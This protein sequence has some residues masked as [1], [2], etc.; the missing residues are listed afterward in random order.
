MD[1]IKFREKNSQ[2]LNRIELANQFVNGLTYQEGIEKEL[3]FYYKKL[4]TGSHLGSLNPVY[5]APELSAA[6]IAVAR[7]N[8]GVSGGLMV[9]GSSLSGKT[10]FLETIA[11]H[12][13]KGEKYYISPFGKQNYTA[14]DIDHAIQNAFGKKGSA[15][16]ILSQLDAQSILIFDDLEQ[17]WTKSPKG[18]QSID[19]LLTLMEK[20][21]HQHYFLLSCN[22]SSFDIIRKVTDIDKQLIATILVPPASKLELKEILLN[23]HK[24]AGDE[25]WYDNH[26]IG[27]SKKTDAIFHEIYALSKGNVGV[28]LNMWIHNIDKDAD[29]QLILN[30]PRTMQFPEITD[31]N[32]KIVLYHLV[33]HGSWSISQIELIFAEA[34]W[35]FATL[36][37]LEKTGLVHQ[38][39]NTVYVLHHAA[40]PY[41]E[42]WLATLKILN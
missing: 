22:I 32:W 23:R 30:K 36:K 7:I 12:Q 2:Y 10:Y 18:A 41:I 28:A 40:K 42:S 5:K 16:A 33:L 17:W 13:L 3:S 20:F 6:K 35:I 34:D 26:L 1:A 37:E 11:G 24:T 19:Y 25:L 39:S 8:R 4:F 31:P 21:G 38:Q 27:N 29:G 9:L 15:S 14:K